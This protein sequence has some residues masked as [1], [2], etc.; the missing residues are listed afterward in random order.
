VLAVKLSVRI[1]DES[2]G[3][4]KVFIG[5]AFLADVGC[6]F[7]KSATYKH[8]RVD[9]EYVHLTITPLDAIM[10]HFAGGS[11]VSR[12]SITS[13]IDTSSPAAYDFARRI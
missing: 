11:R 5:E 12:A 9:E 6:E 13:A 8:G 3:T 10:E 2:K 4:G 7:S 1:S